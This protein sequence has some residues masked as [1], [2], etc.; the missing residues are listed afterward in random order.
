VKRLLIR[1]LNMLGLVTA[2]RYRV[3][4]EQLRDSE[5]RVKKLT[6]VLEATRSEIKGWKGKTNEA[7]QRVK[8]LERDAAKRE[9]RAEK[10]RHDLQ[11]QMSKRQREVAHLQTQ[12]DRLRKTN[13]EID[14]LLVRLADAERELSVA[15]EHLMAVDVKLDILEGAANVLDVRT[16]SAIVQQAGKTNASV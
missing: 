11:E 14:E 1:L 16:R 5:S 8:T 12:V 4:A 2:G 13:A 7:A 10:E 3:V 6:K 9:Q 15:R